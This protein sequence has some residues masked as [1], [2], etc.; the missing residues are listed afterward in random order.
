MQAKMRNSFTVSASLS[1]DEIMKKCFFTG[2][3]TLLPLAISIWFALFLIDFLTRPFLGLTSH[4][5]SF[6]H[7][8]ENLIRIVSQ[9]FILLFLF[10]F[11]LGLGLFARRFLISLM[12][13]AGDKILHKIPLINKIYKTTKELINALFSGEKKTFQNVVLLRFP[14]E[15]CFVLGLVA[16]EG[17]EQC[18]ASA[19]EHL[20][21]VFIPT[22]PNPTTGFLVMRRKSD[23]IYLDM[24]TED[25]IKYI[26]SCGVVHPHKEV[27]RENLSS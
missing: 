22:T 24:N 6:I 2:L 12:L 14:Y 11:V 3:V 21:T 5:L 26:V 20:F 19:N 13:K 9:I 7:I 27:K 25:A 4:L 23:L 18:S 16:N 8:P 15:S 17:P 1:H 10:L